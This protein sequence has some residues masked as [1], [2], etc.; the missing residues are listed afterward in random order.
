[1]AVTAFQVLQRMGQAEQAGER[2]LQVLIEHNE[3]AHSF[4]STSHYVVFIARPS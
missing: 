1:M 2:L 3:D 4:R